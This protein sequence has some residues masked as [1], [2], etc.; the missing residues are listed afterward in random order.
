[1][2][3]SA[4]CSKLP[5]LLL[6]MFLILPGISCVGIGPKSARVALSAKDIQHANDALAEGD[7]AF[8]KK[9]HYAALIK[10]LEA[11]RYNPHSEFIY[12]RLGIAYA[13]LKFYDQATEALQRATRLNPQFSYGFN[14][15]GSVY[16]L[17]KRYGKAEKLFKKAI[18]LYSS[19]ASF[20]MNLGNLYLEKK[21]PQKAIIEWRKALALD[22]LALTRSSAVNL[23]GAGRTSP[24]ERHYLMAGLYASEKKVEQAIESLKLAFE[25]GFS[26]IAAIEKNPNFDPIR[27]DAQFL[28]FSKTMSLLIRL[29]D[30]V[31]LP[32]NAPKTPR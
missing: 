10:Y 7:A 31:G 17:Q 1:M 19:E 22:P 14:N 29:R 16:F 21:K 28:E 12:N 13:Q 3:I 15:L 30:K 5:V 8:N 6:G 4:Q 24:M 9:D 25:S 27:E 2:R 20:H 26:D 11:V 23:T 18:R 32:E